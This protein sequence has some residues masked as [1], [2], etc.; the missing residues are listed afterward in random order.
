M[1][2]EDASSPGK[3]AAL[4]E[5]ADMQSVEALVRKLLDPGVRQIAWLGAMAMRA[6]HHV[7]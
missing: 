4:D 5:P 6:T 3:A 2:V 7:W 1:K